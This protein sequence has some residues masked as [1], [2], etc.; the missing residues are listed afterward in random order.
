MNTLSNAGG[1]HHRTMTEITPL[2]DNDCFYMVDRLK[3]KFDFPIHHHKEL[4]LN[5]I[6]N[7]KGGQRIVGDS[8]EETDEY[9]LAIIGTGLEHAWVQNEIEE[10]REM[11][12]ITIQWDNAPYATALTSKTP[13]QPLR[14]MLE[15]AQYGIAFGQDTIKKVIPVFDE[16]L[17]DLPGFL[18]FHKFVY[19]LWVL[20]ESE[21]YR[22][23]STSSFARMPDTDNSRRITKIKSHIAAH[24]SQPLKLED[25]ADLAGM[26]P[27]AFSRFFKTHTN[28]TLQ[29]YII[30]IRLG[31]A[32]RALVDTAMSTSEVCYSSGF[33][34]ISNFNRLFKKKK[35]C[36][37]MEFRKRYN[38]NKIII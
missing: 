5:F 8:V 13:F 12:E 34:N 19:L 14:R 2:S 22:P 33:N 23:L 20:A 18:L 4:E 9:D 36:T 6:S 1:A 25:L 27:T 38:K 7:C 32:I 21:D 24:Y 29:D 11:R 37:P 35:G 16:L 3:R 31:H 17:E 10:T 30:D 15:K 26:T 28:K